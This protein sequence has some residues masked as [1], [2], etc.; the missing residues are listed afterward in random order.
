MAE[1]IQNLIKKIQEEGIKTAQE[2]AKDIESRAKLE[3]QA[4]IEK[5]RR[6]A[7]KLILEAREKI[8]REESSSNVLLKQVA[9]DLLLSLRR[10]LEQMLQKLIMKEVQGM[11][12]AGEL[13][14]IITSL[15]KEPPTTYSSA[16][17]A[18]NKEDYAHLEGHF[19]GKLKEEVKKDIVLKPS[20]EISGG[21]TISFDQGKSCFDFTDK[22]LSE[23]ISSSLKPKLSEILNGAA[24]DSERKK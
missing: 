12:K 24:S 3:A 7:E 22:A 4:I 11:F 19:L 15:L 13:E 16:L 17:V 9:R 10:E 23:Y 1:N 14:K 6:E 5:A 20:E 21:F 2:Q 18:L 8:S